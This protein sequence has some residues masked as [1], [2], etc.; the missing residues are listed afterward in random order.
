VAGTTIAV[1]GVTDI[2]S[3][4]PSAILAGINSI[5]PSTPKQVQA[6]TWDTSLL[7]PV[8][9]YAW[10]GTGSPDFPDWTKAP[11]TDFAD[12][13]RSDAVISA[14]PAS[15]A[16]VEMLSTDGVTSSVLL[17]SDSLVPVA[18]F[19][20]GSVRQGTAYFTAFERYE[21]KPLGGIF[22]D[23]DSYTGRRSLLIPVTITEITRATNPLGKE[24]GPLVITAWIKATAAY[25]IRLTGVGSNTYADYVG[26]STGGAWAKVSFQV[27]EFSGSKTAGDFLSLAIFNSEP[28]AQPVALDNIM[29]APLGASVQAVVRDPVTFAPVAAIDE[30]GTIVRSINDHFDRPIATV[31]PDGNLAGM[32]STY[33][34]RQRRASGAF[35]PQ[36]PNT[37]IQLAFYNGG[38]HWRFGSS[39]DLDGWTVPSGSWTDQ[40]I[41]LN[42]DQQMSWT[43]PAEIG[44]SFSRAV[45]VQI[46]AIGKGT[47][48]T[49]P[50]VLNAQPITLRWT[51]L[52]GGTLQ[53]TRT[54]VPD[55]SV[56]CPWARDW[57]IVQ[58]GENDLGLGIPPA[59]TFYVVADG[60]IV[61]SALRN[62]TVD[63]LT[64][65]SISNGAIAGGSAI[66]VRDIALGLNPSASIT[67]VDG[68]GDARQVQTHETVST[69]LIQETLYDKRKTGR[70]QTVPTRKRAT[71]PGSAVQTASAT[72]FAFETAFIDGRDPASTTPNAVNLWSTNPADQNR[73][74]MGGLVQEWR[75]ADGLD[76]TSSFFSYNGVYP[77]K[78]PLQR[79]KEET[80]SGQDFAVAHAGSVRT[81]YGRD[82]SFDPL[83][84]AAGVSARDKPRFAAQ[85]LSTPL[86]HPG[87]PGSNIPEVRAIARSAQDSLGHLSLAEATS[88]AAGTVPIR[89]SSAMSWKID[90]G[91]TVQSRMPNSFV[92]NDATKYAVITELD[93]FGRPVTST[94]PDRG[95]STAVF[96]DLGRVR[97]AQDAVGAQPTPSQFFHYRD[98]DREG[99]V[100]QTGLVVGPNWDAAKLQAAAPYPAWRTRQGVRA[101]WR[102]DQVPG[103]SNLADSSGNGLTGTFGGKGTARARFEAGGPNALGNCLRFTRTDETR[104]E[105][106]QPAVLQNLQAITISAWVKIGSMT[107]DAGIVVGGGTS[108]Y[109]SLAYRASNPSLDFVVGTTSLRAVLVEAQKT[110]WVHVVA[111]QAKDSVGL[112]YL[113]GVVGAGT[114]PRALPN[115]GLTWLIGGSTDGSNASA[116]FDG[117]L[118]DVRIYPTALGDS[119]V[120]ALYFEGLSRP[121]SAFSYD[122][123]GESISEFNG[124]PTALLTYN[125]PVTDA[126]RPDLADTAEGLVAERY[127]YDVNGRVTSQIMKVP[128][129]DGTERTIGYRYD[130]LG[131]VVQ[132]IYP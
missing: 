132:V 68:S 69:V 121:S 112:L 83:F 25:R 94:G 19:S 67:Y 74:S 17:G 64:T 55:V 44:E 73:G 52:N 16:P 79:A 47:A 4:S 46:E 51:S 118:R 53:V 26:T 7:S 125:R 71:P 36:S 28:G 62:G 131:N 97:F 58:L 1:L 24:A 115:A 101:S 103:S 108:G 20:S 61:Y 76:I 22:V 33:L 27:T 93:R 111:V 96:D 81:S 123:P 80:D 85:T 34:S 107:G 126:G 110:H 72:S 40:A 48:P 23:G 10:R 98:Y 99:R 13:V 116:F 86:Q 90:A 56:P 122:Y 38:K 87:K 12:W 77:S 70:F 105:I 6:T 92:A 113:D 30:R 66:L 31:G 9:S 35:D 102:C 60:D 129:F 91:Q 41:K 49:G 2:A 89:S 127:R 8:A 37:V 32:T 78:D 42:P 130:A 106:G 39:S 104:V 15:A 124:L 119:L 75:R 95:K 54:G 57:L 14:D 18:T 65:I 114:Q 5:I 3:S 45:R 128:D 100:T 120:R 88:D 109:I 84:A 29:I 117:S 21:R 82:V 50:I 11:G 43:H 63:N 59:M